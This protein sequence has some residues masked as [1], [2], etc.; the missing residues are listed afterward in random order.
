MVR[1]AMLLDRQGRLPEAI[2]AYQR[3][4]ARWPALPDCWYSLALLQRKSRQFHAALASYQRA[5]D[6]GV[7]KPEEVHLNRGVIY[8]DY[9]RQDDQAE[10]ELL[11]ALALNPAYVPALFNLGNLHEDLGRREAALAAYERILTLDPDSLQALARYANLH[12]FAFLDDPLIGRLRLALTRASASA[13][14]RAS[15][16][17]A[18][19]RALDGCGQYAAAFDAY[20]AANRASRESAAP[21]T[22]RYE[23]PVEE[24]FVDRLVAAFPGASPAPAAN[25]A[26]ASSP[27]AS[28]AMAQNSGRSG[29]P[30]PIFVCGMFRSGSTLVEQMLAGHAEVTAGGELDFLPHIAQEVLAPFPESMGSVLPSRLE[31][32]AARYLDTLAALFPGAQF[33]TDKRPDNFVY[34]GLIKTLFPDAK[35][36]H[37]TRDPLDNCLSMFFLHL[38]HRMSYALDLMDIGHHYRQY[39]RLMAHW[40][41]I[42]GADILDVSYDTYVREP[43]PVAEDLLAF[44]GLEWDERCLMPAPAGRAVK[45]ASV[46]QVREPLYRRSSGRA[47]HYASQLDALRAYLEQAR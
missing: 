4:L 27:A 16:G 10:R 33:V 15:L 28:P 31:A 44:L 42:Y 47:R 35:I 46:W 26:P 9:L 14:D 40:K 7:R 38:D 2:S 3:I 29:S 19:G 30:R 41:A 39:L 43:Q 36:V 23:R 12:P 17:F 45:T 25:P 24:R 18:L 34:I 37:T 13:A 5:L 22:A 1:E 11:A 20:S 21:N 6:Q 8:A 32:L